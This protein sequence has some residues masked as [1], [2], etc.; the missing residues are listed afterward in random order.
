MK[1]TCQFLKGCAD[2]FESYITCASGPLLCMACPSSSGV[3][4]LLLKWKL[5]KN[6]IRIVCTLS[7]GKARVD[8]GPL[9]K[10]QKYIYLVNN[11]LYILKYEKK[12]I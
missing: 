6:T 4:I 5:H 7:K 3:R 1:Y 2:P 10:K 11:L 9:T 12:L 8:P